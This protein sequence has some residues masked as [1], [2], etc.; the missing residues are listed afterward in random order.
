MSLQENIRP[1]FARDTYFKVQNE[2]KLFL[3]KSKFNNL[4]LKNSSSV[5]GGIMDTL[6]MSDSIMNMATNNGLEY[7]SSLL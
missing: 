6:N 7:S 2:K 3:F 5:Q 1:S 4:L